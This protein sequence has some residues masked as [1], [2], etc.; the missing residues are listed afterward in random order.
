MLTARAKETE[1]RPAPFAG[2]TQPGSK[3]SVVEHEEH[4]NNFFKEI[5]AEKEPPTSEQMNIL[6]D[7][8]N[9]I[10]L[11]LRLEKEGDEVEK[12]RSK[13]MDK[14]IEPMRG[15]IH[16]PPGTGFSWFC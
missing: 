1:E 9:R 5:A 16:G 6:R 8:K 2:I 12:K 14:E 11:E 3:V 13:S 4:L 7:V 15:L 10:L